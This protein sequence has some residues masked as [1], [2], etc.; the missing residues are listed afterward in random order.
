MTRHERVT[1]QD[2]EKVLKTI[3]EK[4]ELYR[5]LRAAV[6][7]FLPYTLR[8]SVRGRGG[9]VGGGGWGSL[10]RVRVPVR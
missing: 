2:N 5:N 1:R 3:Y 8:L 6:V 7:A 10:V 9:W 4:M